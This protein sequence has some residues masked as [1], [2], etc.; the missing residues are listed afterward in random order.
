[1]REFGMAI[2]GRAAYDLT[3]SEMT[4]PYK[5]AM[6]IGHA[7]HGAEIVIKA[8]IAQ[9]HPLL[10]FTQLPK[11][12]SAEDQL[13]IVQLFEYGRT[14]PYNEL[15]ETLWATTGIRLKRLKQ[16]HDFGKLRNTIIHFAVPDTD[17]QGEAIRFLFEIMEPLVRDLWKETIVPH[18]AV[19]DEYVWETDGLRGQLQQNGVELTPDLMHTLDKENYT[20][21]YRRDRLVLKVE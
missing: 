2:L 15:P 20:Y 14:I 21:D 19:W 4:A 10:L 12:T 1:M 9:E 11:S 17:Y 7:A 8:R 16:F 5:H 18:A 6:A 3:F 13:T